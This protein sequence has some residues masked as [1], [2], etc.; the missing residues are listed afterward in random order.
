VT[1]PSSSIPGLRSSSFSTPSANDRGLE[2]GPRV[3]AR[4]LQLLEDVG[5]GGQAERVVDEV[6]RRQRA[7]RPRVADQRPQ[8]AAGRASR[9]RR[10]TGYASGCTLDASSGSS[11]SR[12]R[13]KPAHCSNALGPSRATSCSA[14]RCGT[15]RCCRGGPRCSRPACRRCRRPWS[16]AA[17]TPC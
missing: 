5:D 4:L 1:T 3:A 13:R 7:Q 9:M 17:P 10:T 16:A 2:R 6:G 11:P 15:G 8:V 12:M 14:A